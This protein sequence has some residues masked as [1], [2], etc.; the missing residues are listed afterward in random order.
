MFCRTPATKKESLVSNQENRTYRLTESE[1]AKLDASKPFID[2][3]GAIDEESYSYVRAA[4]VYLQS[5]NS[6][7]IEVIISSGG[8]KVHY[9]L[10]IYDLLLKYDGKK[11]GVVY[12]MAA[13]MA[14]IILQACDVRTC[15][16]HSQV[17]IHHVSS[18]EVSLDEL[19]SPKRLE[20]LRQDM[21]R[22]QDLLYA[23]LAE[24]TGQSIPVIRRECAKDRPLKAEEAR[25]FGLIDAIV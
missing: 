10:L 12:E 1:M 8:G 18:N 19:R 11:V 13:S 22:D 21:E 9:G 14:A 3:Y 25:K 5:K 4:I 20:K 2:I 15:T 24:K 16:K 17:L 6:P 23:I 7:P